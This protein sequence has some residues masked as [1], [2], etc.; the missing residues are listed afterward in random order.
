VCREP[1]IIQAAAPVLDRIAD[2]ESDKGKPGNATDFGKNGLVLSAPTSTA[3]STS[4]S[5][6]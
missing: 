6:K 5:T 1:R 2:C 4:P 3:R